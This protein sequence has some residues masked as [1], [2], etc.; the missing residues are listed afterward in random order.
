M[1][2][3]ETESHAQTERV[4]HTQIKK[5]FFK[6]TFKKPPVLKKAP[7][8]KPLIIPKIIHQI[9]IGGA[10]PEKYQWMTATWKEK[11]PDWTYILWTDDK[12]KYL[13]LV[14]RDQFDQAPNYGA[15]ADILRY[16]LLER[17]GGVYIDIDYECLKPFDQLH[18]ENEFYACALSQ[19][20]V[21]NAIIGCIPHHPILKQCIDRVKG[22]KFDEIDNQSIIKYVGPKMLTHCIFRYWCQYRKSPI[23]VFS[24]E[25]SFP[26]PAHR[27]HDYWNGLVTNAEI[28]EYRNS[29]AFAIHYWATSWQK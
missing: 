6:R 26:M 9:W 27:R 19:S 24:K 5:G 16:E 13:D 7:K 2:A 25:F 3:S 1:I 15:K 11:H 12:V 20:E 18:Y 8:N 21:A 10:L 29:S 28:E 22:V 23:T 4:Y 14:N 17:Y